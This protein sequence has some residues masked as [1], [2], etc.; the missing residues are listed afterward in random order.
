MLNKKTFILPIL[1]SLS[2][3]TTNPLMAA[4]AQDGNE[5]IARVGKADLTRSEFSMMID[6]MPPQVQT[7]LHSNEEMQKEL[8]NR[9]V[10]INLMAQEA[11]ATGLDK[12]P[13]VALKIDEMR[14][15]F[16]VEALI[17]E[18]LDL[19]P[20]VSED[21]ITAYY[22]DNAA[23]FE[24]GEQVKAQHIL[25]RVAPTAGEEDQAKAKETIDMIQQKLKDGASFAKLAEEY[26]EDPGS[27]KQGG[28]LGYFGKGQMVKEFEEAAFATATGMTSDPVKTNFGWHLIHVQDK[29]AP[30]KLPLDQVKK[31]IENKLKAKHN[32][33]AIQDLVTKLRG[34]YEVMIK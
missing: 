17:A 22:N 25:I 12:D 23:E 14:N 28:N 16:L 8:I 4:D 3:L 29:K 26:S 31:Q 1:V 30:Q 6:L 33:E 13:K 20:T 32:D 15:R 24:Q 7:M 9:W 11:L 27:K 21:E 34:K 10:E 2:L 19:S 18:K 5:V